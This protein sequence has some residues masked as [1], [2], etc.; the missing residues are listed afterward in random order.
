M[1]LP[2]INRRRAAVGY[3][4]FMIARRVARR[5]IRQRVRAMSPSAFARRARPRVRSSA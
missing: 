5:K 3:F 4:A 1:K 2:S